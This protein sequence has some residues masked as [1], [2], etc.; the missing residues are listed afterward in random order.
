MIIGYTLIWGRSYMSSKLKVLRWLY[1][2]R[3][4]IRAKRAQVQKLRRVEDIKVLAALGKT[5][6]ANQLSTNLYI[7]K[8]VEVFNFLFK[9]SY[10]L[11]KRFL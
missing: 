6:P 4:L 2:N 5:M 8:G 10:S 1:R 3:Q 7:Q 9:G 11:L